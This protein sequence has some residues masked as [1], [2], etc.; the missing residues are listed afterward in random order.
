MLP[1]IVIYSTNNIF[2]HIYVLHISKASKYSNSRKYVTNHIGYV[3]SNSNNHILCNIINHFF[4]QILLAAIWIICCT[5]TTS[6]NRSLHYV[7]SD[8]NCLSLSLQKGWLNANLIMIPN[9][10]LFPKIIRMKIKD[11]NK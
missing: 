1:I 2:R 10:N 9:I 4:C 5:M 8:T 7:S 11:Y 6:P 3:T